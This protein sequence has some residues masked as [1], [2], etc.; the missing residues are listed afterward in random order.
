MYLIGRD[1]A[2]GNDYWTASRLA[3]EIDIPS[4][5]LA[6]VIACLERGGL[7][8]ATEKE[9]FLPGRNPDAILL[10]EILDAVRRLQTGRLMIGLHSEK[11]PARV[12]REVEA[13]AREQLGTRSLSD[14]I[15]ARP[16]DS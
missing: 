13:A 7:L 5:A 4:I 3:D 14:L 15:S 2:A 9:Q 1:Y 12:M 8:V 11:A 6:P 16:D 10:A